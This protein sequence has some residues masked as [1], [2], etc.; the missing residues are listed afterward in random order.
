MKRTECWIGIAVVLLWSIGLNCCCFATGAC[1][2][3][4][5]SVAKSAGSTGHGCCSPSPPS[6]DTDRSDDRPAGVCSCDTHDFRFTAQHAPSNLFTPPVVELRAISEVSFRRPVE[7]GRSVF[8]THQNLLPPERAPPYAT[9][10][11]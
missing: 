11:S 8:E 6:S 1:G 2:G 5:D 9:G 10:L 4:S 3:A 7:I